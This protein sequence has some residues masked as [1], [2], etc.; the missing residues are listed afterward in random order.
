M[1]L[2]IKYIF[3]CEVPCHERIETQIYPKRSYRERRFDYRCRPQKVDPA[4]SFLSEMAFTP[5]F[6]TVGTR[7]EDHRV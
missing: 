5:R 4:G 6:L 1:Q 2:A 7:G 3:R